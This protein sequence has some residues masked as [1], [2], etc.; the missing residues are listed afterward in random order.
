[1]KKV[2]ENY[3]VLNENNKIEVFDNAKD[4][5]DRYIE[6]KLRFLQKRKE[7]Q[8]QKLT[9]DIN[10]DIS[11]FMFIKNIVDDKLAINKRKKSE[12]ETDLDGIQDIIKRD[13]SYD[14]LLRMSVLNLTDEEMEKLQKK[15]TLSKKELDNLIKSSIEDIWLKE[16]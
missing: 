2:S 7:Y 5:L 9:D 16:L 3:T 11:K 6:V 10:I 8:L 12:I 14:Y 15:I 4:I 13:G 1:M